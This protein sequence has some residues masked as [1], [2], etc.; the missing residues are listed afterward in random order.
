M[1]DSLLKGPFSS[2]L[3]EPHTS[4]PVKHTLLILSSADNT[5]KASTSLNSKSAFSAVFFSLLLEI[6]F[7][8]AIMTIANKMNAT[9]R[10]ITTPAFEDLPLLY[11]GIGFLP[12]RKHTTPL[13]AVSHA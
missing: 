6:L 1:H 8:T 3:R 10:V 5:L 12:K 7:R 9:R 2:V 4:H 13:D 11:F